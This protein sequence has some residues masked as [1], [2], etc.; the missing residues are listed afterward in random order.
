MK[1]FGRKAV[2]VG[3][4]SLTDICG[5]S[6]QSPLPALEPEVAKNLFEVYAGCRPYWKVM[7]QCLPSGLDAN[8]YARLH[9]SFERLQSIGLEHMKWLARKAG[10]SS[11]KQQ[12]IIGTATARVTATAKGTCETTPSLIQEYRDKCAALFENVK[13]ALK[14]PPPRA[15]PALAAENADSA[16]KFIVSTCYEPIDDISRVSSYARM[17]K[18]HDL[19]ADAK[20]LMKPADSTFFEGWEVDHDGLTYFVSVSRGHFKGRPTEIC[21]VTVQQRAGPII[22]RIIGA[23]KVRSLGTNSD[24]GQTKELYELV[25]HPSVRSGAMMVERAGD[26]RAFF[27]VAFMGIK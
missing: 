23:V 26:D 3:L 12:Q 13:A 9:Q 22:S 7:D 5:S 6:A 1:P 21:Q 11:A 20:N 25:S 16:A 27:T 10:I 4:L 19:P 14:E 17:M 8:D 24:G 18:W 2:L 15:D